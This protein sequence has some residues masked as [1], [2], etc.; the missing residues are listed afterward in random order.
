MSFMAL[1]A[2]VDS[3]TSYTSLLIHPQDLKLT[4]TSEQVNTIVCV[5]ILATKV[6]G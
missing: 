6:L 3:I 4:F 1:V 5:S 2:V